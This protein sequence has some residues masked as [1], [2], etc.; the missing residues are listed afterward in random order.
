MAETSKC[1]N[2]ANQQRL[3]GSLSQSLVLQLP[4]IPI[5]SMEA[6]TLAAA[7]TARNGARL[8][9]LYANSPGLARQNN[10]LGANQASYP[11]SLSTAP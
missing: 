1:Q 8:C 7:T 2:K 3:L 9:I 10:R 6:S 4:T 5:T 11:L